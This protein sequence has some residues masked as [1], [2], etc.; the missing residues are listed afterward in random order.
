MAEEDIHEIWA[1]AV[2]AIK[3]RPDWTRRGNV[4]IDAV[5]PKAVHGDLVLLEVPHAQFR[6]Y[7]E[8]DGHG[9]LSNA[10]ASVMGREV[11]FAVN[12]NHTLATEASPVT[13]PA[14]DYSQ[15]DTDLKTPPTAE[16]GGVQQGGVGPDD[17]DGQSLQGNH[18]S[19]DSIP[20]VSQYANVSRD[21]DAQN[22]HHGLD[23]HH[24]TAEQVAEPATVPTGGPDTEPV[25]EPAPAAP[26]TLLNPKYTFDAF[27]R[28]DSNRMAHATCI[29]VAE[30]PAK[31][32]NPLFIYGGSGLGKTHLLHAIGHYTHH[33]SPH[34]RIRYVNAEELMNDF[35][36]SMKS[37]NQNA[38]R[39]RYR[40]VDVLL[41]D[42]IQLLGGKKETLKEFFH[43][44]NSLHG[45]SKQIVITS[46]VPP[47]QLEGFEDRL[48][49]RF[50]WGLIANIDPPGPELRIAIL[51]AKAAA[52]G[53]DVPDEVIHHLASLNSSNVRE[54]EGWL[55][56]VNAYA[57]LN[58]QEL[59]ADLAESVLKDLVCVEERPEVTVD[60][61]IECASSYFGFTRDDII[62]SQ[63]TRALVTARQV[64]MY[65]TRELTELSLPMIAKA[66]AKKDHSTV[67]HANRKIT[68]LMAERGSVYAQVDELTSLIHRSTDAS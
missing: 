58:R 56:R 52:Q 1:D 26:I 68:G 7:L 10:L 41:M 19:T 44:F 17:R 60:R 62:G 3:E 59:T 55:I 24:G 4:Y 34:L 11:Q 16:P 57:S 66:F 6:A 27:V 29:G 31:A 28:G 35:I 46:D 38:F 36:N 48:V 67:V 37:D 51:R 39:Q 64:A 2:A 43:T 8:N 33:L 14:L 53:F 54:L 49:T 13:G 32:Y 18:V 23:P 9:Q 42:D 65:L 25:A 45:A 5:H 20:A 50:E 47:K 40:D 15:P 61:V 30:S 22:P 12:I 21:G 63:R